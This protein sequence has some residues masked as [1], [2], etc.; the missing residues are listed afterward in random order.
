M[1]SAG[2]STH[3]LLIWLVE[4]VCTII[5]HI[6]FVFF[7]L[8]CLNFLKK[9]KVLSGFF[10]D[11]FSWVLWNRPSGASGQVL[12]LERGQVC[13]LYVSTNQLQ[14][15]ASYLPYRHD[16]GI[17]LLKLLA[18]K[19]SSVIP[20]MSNFAFESL[21]AAGTSSTMCSLFKEVQYTANM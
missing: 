16:S 14:L 12:V 8:K 5:C 2:R 3:I 13:C 10:P 1:G 6:V 19:W 18:R 7:F 17:N 20:K 15:V 4:V 11:F 9:K 21:L